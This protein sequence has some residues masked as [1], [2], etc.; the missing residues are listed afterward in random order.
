MHSFLLAVDEFKN[1]PVPFGIDSWVTFWLYFVIAFSNSLLLLLISYKYFQI[2]QLSGY[3]LKGL[4]AWFTDTKFKN[5]YLLIMLSFLSASCLL[6][7]DV[8]L[9]S[10]FKYRILTFIGLI[11]YIIFTAIFARNQFETPQK[12]PLRYTKRMTRMCIIFCLLVFVATFFLTTIQIKFSAIF[13]CITPVFIPIFVIVAF[14]ITAPLEL[15][16]NHYYVKKAMNVLNSRENPLIV[17]GITGSYGKTSCKNILSCLLSQRYKVCSSPYSYNTPMGLSKTILENLKDEHQILVCEMGAKCTGDI[18]YLTRM[19]KPTIG[20]ITGIGNQHLASFGSIENLKNTKFELIENLKKGGRAYFNCD[21]QGA[22]ELYDRAMCKKERTSLSDM[23]GKYFVDDIKTGEKGSTFNLHLNG[24]SVKCSTILLG[25]HNVS[26]ILLCSAV[27]YD[28][29]LTKGEIRE[30]IER[31][32]PS[33]HRLAIVPS[34]NALVVLDDA[35]NASVE[36]SNAA[37][38]VLASFSGRKFVV[39]PGLIELGTEN[40][41]ANFEFGKNMAKVADEVIIVGVEN[42]DAIFD[43]LIFGGFDEK[44]ITNVGSLPQATT[45]LEMHAKPHDVVLF[46]N[47]LPDNYN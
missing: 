26:N 34:N 13:V 28:L 36:G 41:N 14:L 7:T 46:E 2:L 25:K 10:F 33:S 15:L 32:L 44:N 37:L 9:E 21:T 20:I 47:D 23:N 43:G 19:I 8:L 38:E 11:F 35:F 4:F 18:E 27:A 30:G 22:L 3:N 1:V 17:I 39:T 12:T 42:R 16:I 40:F 24:D 29:G 45:I 5:Y 31:L 6:M